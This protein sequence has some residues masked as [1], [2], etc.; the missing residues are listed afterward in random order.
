MRAETDLKHLRLDGRYVEDEEL[1]V[2]G[3]P[4]AQAKAQRFDALWDDVSLAAD[5]GHDDPIR[6]KGR[7]VYSHSVE[8]T[9]PT[10]REAKHTAR[11]LVQLG[12]GPRDEHGR[13]RCRT[14]STDKKGRFYMRRWKRKLK[15]TQND[16]RG[17]YQEVSGDVPF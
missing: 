1:E 9:F 12:Y 11:K 13:A 17:Y 4:L 5:N 16:L 2:K 6:R 8:V 10:K 7:R 3:T 15:S 14:R